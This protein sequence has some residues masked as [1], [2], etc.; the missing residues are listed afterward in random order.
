MT[1]TRSLKLLALLAGAGLVIA[2]CGGDDSGSSGTTPPADTSGIEVVV[3]PSSDRLQL[4]QPF[5]TWDGDDFVD[6]PIQE[7]KGEWA[8]IV[9]WHSLEHLPDAGEAFDAAAAKLARVVGA[10]AAKDA[11]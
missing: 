9:F 7:M 6:L 3:D 8:A 1:R 5:P 2:A 11:A 10:Y 4:L